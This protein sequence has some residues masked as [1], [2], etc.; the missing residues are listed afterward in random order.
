M[1]QRANCMAHVGRSFAGIVEN[2]FRLGRCCFADY[3]RST[4]VGRKFDVASVNVAIRPT[5]VC[6]VYAV[7]RE[8][9]LDR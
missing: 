1:L 8:I 2:R 9:L 5:I 4:G 7:L 6:F 3:W